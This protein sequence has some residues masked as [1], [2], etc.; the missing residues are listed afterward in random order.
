MVLLVL[1]FSIEKKVSPFH[2]PSTGSAVKK[3][4]A[5]T[6]GDG[7]GRADIMHISFIYN[8]LYEMQ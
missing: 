2:F 8:E 4:N 1:F 6:K 5:T 3:N 7:C